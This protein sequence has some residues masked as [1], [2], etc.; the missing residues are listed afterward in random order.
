M[1]TISDVR[2]FVGNSA[3]FARGRIY[4]D[5]GRVSTIRTETEPDGETV[6]RASVRGS[7][8]RY[9]VFV[10]LDGEVPCDCGCDCCG[11][12]FQLLSAEENGSGL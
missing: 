3:Y 10:R 12:D 4:A 9:D 7:G 5:E 8:A 6:L 11:G 2:G 1:L